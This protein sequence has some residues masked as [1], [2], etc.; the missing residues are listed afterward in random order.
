MAVHIYVLQFMESEAEKTKSEEEHL[1]RASEV[2]AIQQQLKAMEKKWNR[3]I[4]KSKPYFELKE[5]FELQLEVSSTMESLQ[6]YISSG[7]RLVS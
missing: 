2:A 7:D 4:P 6:L 3:T 1:K 5:N